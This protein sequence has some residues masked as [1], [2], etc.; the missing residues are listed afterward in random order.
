V[1][2]TIKVNGTSNTLV[3]KG[4]SGISTATVPDVCKTPSPGGPV[5]IPYPNI[6]KSSSLD[7]GTT[8]VTA[9]GGNMIAIKGSEFSS[10]NG[11]EAGTAGGVKSSVNMK[12]A[13]WILYSFDVKMDGQNACRLS[14]K[15]FHNKE[16]TVNASGEIQAA[17]NL[18]LPE[19]KEYCKKCAAT[20]AKESKRCGRMSDAYK[21]T[22]GAT[23][24]EI[25][26]GVPLT[27]AMT[28]GPLPGGAASIGGKTD[29]DKGPSVEPQKGKCKE[30]KTEAVKR[31]EDSHWD[32]RNKLVAK[33]GAA[34]ARDIWNNDGRDHRKSEVKAYD[35]QKETYDK[36]LTECSNAGA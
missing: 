29:F 17:L 3:H 34:K 2:V 15:M 12:E 4:S 8:T 7:K 10:S 25:E 14:D 21:N 27:Y 19:F 26:E 16:N 28:F 35:K 32:D 23:P 1:S 5:P 9:D 31:H 13:T 6:A 18:E 22:E 20:A 30:L 36:F 33:H 24:A 11:D